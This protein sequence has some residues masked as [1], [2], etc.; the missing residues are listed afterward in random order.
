MTRNQ[1]QQLCTTYHIDPYKDFFALS[2]SDV[3]RVLQAADTWHY[4]KPKSANGSRGRYFFS[5]LQRSLR[6][7][8]FHGFINSMRRLT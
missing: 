8:P 6:D 3:E 5:Y 7:R 4:R 1:A 2:A